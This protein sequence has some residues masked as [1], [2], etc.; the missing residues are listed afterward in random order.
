L[1]FTAEQ[2]DFAPS[3]APPYT[4]S[5]IYAFPAHLQLPYTLQWNVGLEQS[6]G[7]NQSLTLSYVAA[8]G[9][10][11]PAEQS[12][13]LG[14]LNPDFGAVV[15]LQSGVTSNYQALQAQFQ[16]RLSGGI[17]ALASYTWSHSIDFGSTYSSLPL[18]RGN[19]DFDVRNNLSGAL[20]WDLP[21]PNR[22][23]AARLLLN[24]WGLDGR[25]GLRT[26][27]PVTLNGS[28]L[29]DPATG[30]QY[31][32]GVDLVP[33]RPLYLYGPQYPGHRAINGGP[34]ASNPAFVA[35]RGSAV[36]NAP[37]NTVR[38]FGMA[39]VNLAARR[40]F[41]FSE[42]AKLQFRAEAFNVLNHPNFG[43][44]DRYLQDAAFGT[45]TQMLNQSL[46]TMASQY[47]QGGPRSMQFTLMVLF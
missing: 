10:R 31:Y 20:G 14:A 40:E 35:P 12:L 44:I 36:G 46:A 3:S 32:S 29:T 2:L 34:S 19:S 26:G 28:L 8:N 42:Q 17:Q 47:Q 41:R 25:I 16:R 11:L 5:T 7:P 37:R 43:Y 18:M 6:F 15:Y 21:Q 39:Q 38:G 13:S 4:S 45:A 22:D 1:P 23:R 33:G 24:R 30:N 27:F 9:R